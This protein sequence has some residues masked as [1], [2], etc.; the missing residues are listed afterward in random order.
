MVLPFL[1]ASEALERAL[2]GSWSLFLP[3]EHRAGGSP[4]LEEVE[5]TPG[6]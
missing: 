6:L 3:H 1:P 5:K 4:F 2:H